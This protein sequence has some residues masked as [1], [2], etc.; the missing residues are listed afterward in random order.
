MTKKANG[1]EQV[2]PFSQISQL[3]GATSPLLPGEPV[4]AYKAG[5]QATIAELGATSPLQIYLAEK[6]FDC[7]WWIRRYESFKRA[8]I[9][10]AMGDLLK[11]ERLETKI[12]K[13]TSHITQALL[14][15]NLEDPVVVKGMEHHNYTLEILTQEAMAKRRE[16]LANVDEQIALRIKTLNGL[17][18]SYE[19][20]VNRK[21]HIER[22]QLQNELLRRD[23]EA[24]D[25]EAIVHDKPTKTSGKQA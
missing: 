16:Q 10:R 21:I 9:V 22:L 24:V 20:L 1:G 13:T 12:S 8:S 6:I 23:L 2:I 14:D 19:S 3:I 17:Q 7:L 5:L 4:D 11:A 25:V 15:G 18:T